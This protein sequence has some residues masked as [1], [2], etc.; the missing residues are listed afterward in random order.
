MQPTK[1]NSSREWVFGSIPRDWNAL[2]LKNLCTRTSLYGA[3][4]SADAYEASGVR[5]LRTTDIND[6]GTL[7]G[8]GVFVPLALVYDYILS[9]GDFLIS[10]SGTVGRACV[11]RSEYGPCAY[12]GYLVRY[13]L[14]NPNTPRYLFYVTKSH[15]FQQ[16][17]GTVAIEA[18]IDNVNGEKYA[19]LLVPVPPL[20]KQ[21]AITDYLDRKTTRLDALVT[22]KARVLEL[23]AEKRKAV[24]TCAVTRGLD[25]KATLRDSGIMWLGEIPAHWKTRRIAT[26]FRER[27]ERGEPKLPL[28]EVSINTGVVLREFSEERIENTAADFNTYK[29]ARRGDIV[30]NKMR[31]WQGAV[32]VA[33]QDGLVS[34]DY[35]VAASTGPLSPHF[36]GLL[37]RTNIFSAECARRSHG[38][39]WD[40]LRLYW[41][42][43]RE[44]QLPLP[45][46]EE[47]NTIVMHIAKETVN[48]DRLRT[49][50]ERTIFLLK[51]RRTAL[52]TAAVTGRLLIP[53]D[54]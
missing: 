15:G 13:V 26:L 4:V 12:A 48:L 30:F 53:E 45:P 36:A 51:E 35:V 38:I 54:S 22:A 23:L 52:I 49:T 41:E 47:Q 10:R 18:T 29:V 37:F 24:I 6:D 46:T 14:R 7:V 25:P 17:L 44:I 16:W 19:N 27:D 28:M 9:E 5:F 2:P 11:Y 3:N 33:P 39:V 31:M 43:F 1:P 8:E 40:R 32:G 42:S 34:P 21:R 20:P 50:M